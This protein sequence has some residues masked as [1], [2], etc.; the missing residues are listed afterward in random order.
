MMLEDI[1]NVYGT[2]ADYFEM[3]T[4]RIFHF[5]KMWYN[6]FDNTYIVPVSENG[7]VIGDVKM[8]ANE[9]IN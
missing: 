9:I 2:E 6:S 3:S 4:G 5:T 8:D 1:A 7:K